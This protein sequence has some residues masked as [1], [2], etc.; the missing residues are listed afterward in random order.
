MK[1]QKERKSKVYFN[2]YDKKLKTDNLCC[3]RI[4]LG[5]IKKATD[6]L[7]IIEISRDEETIAAVAR[8]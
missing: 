6:A 8:D 2:E 1:N 4:G 7:I 3:P 5:Y